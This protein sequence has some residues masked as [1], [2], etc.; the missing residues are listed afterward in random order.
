M[1][2]VLLQAVHLLLPHVAMKQASIVLWTLVFTAGNLQLTAATKLRSTGKCDQYQCSPG[3][4]P[5]KDS[6][7]ITGASDH[8]CCSKTCKLYSCKN[9]WVGN[10]NYYDNVAQN[11]AECC[12]KSCGMFKD[13]CDD[14][15]GVPDERTAQP[16]VNVSGCCE[17]TCKRF[18]CEVSG[19]GMIQ[20]QDNLDVISS[21]PSV[22]CEEICAAYT[23]C[24]YDEVLAPHRLQDAQPVRPEDKREYCC[25]KTCRAFSNR[26]PPGYSVP[27]NKLHNLTY[28]DSFAGMCCEPL[29]KCAAVTCQPGYTKVDGLPKSAG[30]GENTGGEKFLWTLPKDNCCAPLC[31]SHTCSKGY[32]NNSDNDDKIIS[33]LGGGDEQCC[34][35]SCA[36]YKNCPSGTSVRLDGPKLVDNANHLS[37]EFCCEADLCSDVRR[38][39]PQAG[40]PCNVYNE[41]V[42]NDRYFSF[43]GEEEKLHRQRWSRIKCVWNAT[44]HLCRND[45]S[46]V[47]SDL[48][49]WES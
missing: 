46:N 28:N 42:C 15:F 44:L 47:Q 11:D 13:D 43:R 8:S 36:V 12:D 17:T 38:D 7:K 24:S 9:G 48:C 33:S 3:W 45:E 37:P 39:R 26:C 32:V 35:R 4:V 30:L 31:R 19:S 41:T 5:K 20:K 14:G 6:H 22:C 10:T 27:E 49:S 34:L 29:S 40:N 23:G 2:N 18:I 21:D 16:T 25:A 1:L